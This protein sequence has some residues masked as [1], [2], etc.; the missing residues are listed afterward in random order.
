[1]ARARLQKH[2]HA[3]TVCGPHEF[4]SQL[5][6]ARP[7]KRARS[8]ALEFDLRRVRRFASRHGELAAVHYRV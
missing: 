1:M 4:R 6:F 5:H 3:A 8:A 7:W 2:V